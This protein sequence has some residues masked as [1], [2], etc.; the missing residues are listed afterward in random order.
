M[1]L[2]EI[3]ESLLREGRIGADAYDFGIFRLKLVVTVRT[4]RL[5]V[6]DSGRAEVEDIEV[7]ENV[8]AFEAAELELAA[9]GAVELEVRRL[10]ADLEG[11]G[12]QDRGEKKHEG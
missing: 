7:D 6:L 9:F 11:G 2:G 8:F 4:G 3:R 12:R 1:D 10:V 5:Q